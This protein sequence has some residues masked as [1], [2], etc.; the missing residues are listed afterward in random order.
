MADVPQTTCRMAYIL[1][2]DAVLRAWTA[3]DQYGALT[4]LTGVVEPLA[5]A[6]PPDHG[7]VRPCELWNTLTRQ[8]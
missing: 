6:T 1:A 4:L 8:G 7:T 5:R 3:G 2:V